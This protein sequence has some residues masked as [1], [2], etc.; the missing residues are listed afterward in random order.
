MTAREQ[1]LGPGAARRRPCRVCDLRFLGGRPAA[2]WGDSRRF[3]WF[4]RAVYGERTPFASVLVTAGADGEAVARWG[5]LQ[6]DGRSQYGEEYRG[7][8]GDVQ[9]GESSWCWQARSDDQ[10]FCIIDRMPRCQVGYFI[11]RPILGNRRG[12]VPRGLVGFDF[13]CR[14]GSLARRGQ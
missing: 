3:A 12:R 9:Q 5:R 2:S 1:V 14:F 11:R 4:I 13:R 10:A 7:A 8:P 6:G